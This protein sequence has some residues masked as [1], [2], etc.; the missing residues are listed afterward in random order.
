LVEKR[1]PFK[2]SNLEGRWEKDRNGVKQYVVISYGWY[3]LYIF[4]EDQWFMNDDAYSSSTSKQVSASKPFEYSD[5]ELG[6]KLLVLTRK[7]MEQLRSS[8]SK[9]QVIKLKKE[10][11]VQSKPELSK[12]AQ[13]FSPYIGDWA[14]RPKVKYRITDT[15]IENDK[16]ILKVKITD[17]IRGGESI[18]SQISNTEKNKFKNAIY[19]EIIRKYRGLVG[20]SQYNWG[21]V[22]GEEDGDSEIKYEIPKNL[23]FDVKF[24]D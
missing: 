24:E 23:I 9:D 2:A 11:L 5:P 1:V 7:E 12:R 19:N 4:K 8:L 20:S 10:K 22:S 14:N 16:V 17:I 15:D 18:L 3:P 13:R 21:Y 6:V